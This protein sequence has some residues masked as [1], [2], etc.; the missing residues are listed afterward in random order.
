MAEC[1]HKKL[2]KIAEDLPSTS[3][4]S[5]PMED[6][7]VSG[8]KSDKEP[9]LAAR[10]D[11]HRFSQD[12]MEIQPG[13]EHSQIPTPESA[14]LSGGN[15]NEDDTTDNG[16]IPPT[17]YPNLDPNSHL[18]N[19]DLNKKKEKSAANR[20]DF[21]KS[22]SIAPA[23]ILLRGSSIQSGDRS[24]P[25]YDSDMGYTERTPLLA[26]C[27]SLPT[28]VGYDTA[29]PIFDYPGPSTARSETGRDEMRRRK[30]RMRKYNHQRH[31]AVQ[32]MR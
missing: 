21:K 5:S 2:E 19:D 31:A 13:S 1:A 30:R 14:S 10:I 27:S 7:L 6:N 11:G 25:A 12:P 8:E 15:Q 28:V 24:P 29:G 18:L 20:P 32:K 9:L 4:D 26:P 3:V 16:I 17:V 22:V 23:E